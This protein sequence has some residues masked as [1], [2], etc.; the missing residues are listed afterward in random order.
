[1]QLGQARISSSS[2]STGI[3]LRLLVRQAV[4]LPAVEIYQMPFASC[5]RLTSL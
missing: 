4:S 5:G 2:G 1:L 3:D